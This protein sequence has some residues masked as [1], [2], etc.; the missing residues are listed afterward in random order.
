MR[1]HR[2]FDPH[3]ATRRDERR[4]RDRALAYRGVAAGEPVSGTVIRV[5]LQCARRGSRL[6]AEER[7][8]V[9]REVDEKDG[10]QER[11]RDGEGAIALVAGAVL[12]VLLRV[13]LRVLVLVLV[14]YLT[15]NSNRTL[16]YRSWS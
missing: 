1:I 4:V 5:V 10:L 6:D 11:V 15:L 8:G 12:G 7:V 14:L 13:L 3:S 16:L 2:A 9:A